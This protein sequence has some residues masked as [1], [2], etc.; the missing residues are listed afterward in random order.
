MFSIYSA[1]YFFYYIPDISSIFAVNHL[2]FITMLIGVFFPGKDWICTKNISMMLFDLLTFVLLLYDDR[3]RSAS[4][5]KSAST[6][7]GI[8]FWNLW[9]FFTFSN[10]HPTVSLTY[11]LTLTNKS[12]IDLKIWNMGLRIG[13]RLEAGHPSESYIYTKFKHRFTVHVKSV[14]L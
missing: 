9:S 1:Y 6:Q 5:L 3:L 2:S 4:G 8:Q 12:A 11:A 14:H 7:I 10:W 13:R